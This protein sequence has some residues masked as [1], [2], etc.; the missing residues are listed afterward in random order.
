MQ[1]ILQPGGVRDLLMGNEAIARG[2][3]EARLA[4]TLRLIGGLTT[5]EIARAFLVPE[6]TMAQRL[7]HARQG[8]ITYV[9]AC[10][11]LD[12]NALATPS[13]HRNLQRKDA[14]T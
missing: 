13:Q 11:G 3:I 9:G 8:E 5:E 10:L 1:K 6:P 14:V 2:A 4:L 7:D 12:L